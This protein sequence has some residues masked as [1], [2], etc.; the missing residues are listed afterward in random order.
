MTTKLGRPV[1]PDEI[2]SLKAKITPPEVYDAVNEL[3][4]KYWDGSQSN[5]T[6][7]E[8]RNAISSRIGYCNL[9]LLDFESVY[10]ESGWS[11]VYD[12]P[13]YNESYEANFTFKKK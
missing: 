8:A 1:K 11:V 13:G 4:A 6:L 5:F 9:G 3:I 2:V 12:S 10:R 7:A